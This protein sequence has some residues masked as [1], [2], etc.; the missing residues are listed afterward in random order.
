MQVFKVENLMRKRAQMFNC[1][2]ASFKV[3]NLLIKRGGGGKNFDP[4]PRLFPEKL[5]PANPQVIHRSSTGFPQVYA[6]S[7]SQ[8][9]NII[10]S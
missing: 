1:K 9:T 7:C 2:N 6:H 8:D 10:N 3:E 5:S 4:P